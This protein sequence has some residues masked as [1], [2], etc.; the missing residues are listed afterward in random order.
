M[1]VRPL[2]SRVNLSMNVASARAVHSKPVGYAAILTCAVLLGMWAT[3][4]TLALATIPPL[5]VAA[6]VQAVGSATFAPSLRRLSLTRRQWKLTI[7]AAVAGAFLAPLAYFVGLSRTTPPDA[8]LL[9]NTEAMFTVVLA[10][11][12]LGERLPRRGY[13]AVAAILAGAVLVTVDV[14]ASGGELAPRVI[15]DLL[16]VLAAALWALDNTASRIVTADHD[17]GAY[18]CIKM[19]LGS[20]LLGATALV[21][22]QPLAI[23]ASSLPIALFLGITGSALFTFL[24][25]SSMRTIGALRVG[26]ILG[27]SAAWGV[28]I[29]VAAGFPPPT[30]LQL[31]GGAIMVVAVVALYLQPHAPLAIRPAIEAPADRRTA[32]EPLQKD[33]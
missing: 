9:S 11:A 18:S 22:G 14:S 7:L 27:T 23:P 30:P 3:V 20:I 1:A 24:F 10:V 25:F 26:A 17:I 19:G 32:V 21:L 33:N 31:A 5:V 15:G 8:A 12:V 2:A 13:A 29:A 4:G 6:F 28:A 16:L